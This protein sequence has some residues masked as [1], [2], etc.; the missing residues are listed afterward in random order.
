M[1]NELITELEKLFQDYGVP[2]R[3]RGRRFPEPVKSRILTLIQSG[4]SISSLS[5]ATGISVMTLSS[6]KEQS[7]SKHFQ[8]ITVDDSEPLNGIKFR[9]YITERA[10]LELDESSI[11]AGILQKIRAVL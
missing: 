11:S 4:V 7:M 3:G 2:A 8:K 6:W 5:R 10:W 1:T 9:L